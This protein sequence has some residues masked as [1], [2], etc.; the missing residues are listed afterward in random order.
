MALADRHPAE[1][2]AAD[3]H[4][5]DPWVIAYSPADGKEIWRAECLKADVGPSPVFADG[6]VYVAN[7]FPGVAAIRAGGTGDVTETHVAWTVDQACP[8]AAVPWRRTSSCCC[9][10]SYGIADLLRCQEGGD[11]LWE[12]EFDDADFASSPSLVG[13]RVYLFDE[14]GKVWIVEPTDEECK[15]IAEANLGEGCVTSPAFHDGRMY[16]RGKEHLFCIGGGE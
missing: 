8:T 10:R 15:A 14:E 3:H 5:A 6:L 9:W 11:P 4:G 1:G 2:P 16:I 13:N 12:K 7:E